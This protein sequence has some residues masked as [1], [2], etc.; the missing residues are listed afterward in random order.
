MI[1]VPTPLSENREPDL[2]I[3][4]AATRGRSHP[5]LRRGQLVVLES[6]TYPGTTREVLQPILEQGG[7]DGRARTSTWRCR[8]SGST[9]AAPTG[10]S[11]RR[12]RWSAA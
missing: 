6:T 12:P 11:A 8:P 7:L 1:C 3:I 2:T 4:R 9:P 5:H 10:R